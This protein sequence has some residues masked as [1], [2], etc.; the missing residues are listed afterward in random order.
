MLR[1][2]IC[3]LKEKEQAVAE[4]TASAYRIKSLEAEVGMLQMRASTAETALSVSQESNRELTATLKQREIAHF[5]ENKFAVQFKLTMEKLLRESLEMSIDFV[6]NFSSPSFAP[7]HLSSS[8]TP[9]TNLQDGGNHICT[10]FHS[11]CW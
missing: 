4:A 10:S 9:I 7:L 5:E 6:M 1:S 2:K 3:T 11:K 8:L